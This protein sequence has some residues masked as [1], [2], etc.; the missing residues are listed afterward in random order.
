MNFS[1]LLITGW[2][3]GTQLLHPLQ[4]ALENHA[5]RVEVINIFDAFDAAV[6]QQNVALAR[7][8]DV[9]VGWSLGGQLAA[10]LVNEIE[11][12]YAEH[13][14][15]ITLA[16]NPC[17][18]A[19]DF[20][21]HA[22]PVATFKAFKQSFEH[23]AI[24]TLKRFGY[25]VCQGVLSTKTDLLTLQS[26]IQPQQIQLL[27]QGLVL[28]KNLNVV[29]ILKNYSGQ[30]Y[31]LFAMQD[32]LVPHQVNHD[33]QNLAAKYLNTDTILGAHAF[34]VT[35]PLM[36]SEQIYQYLRQIQSC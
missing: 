21:P 35:Q 4:Q 25:M 8:Y 20:W 11:K 16:S 12:K 17:F 29:D 24:N 33:L 23:D 31:H 9:I 5:H 30:Q 32:A 10:V 3:G 18:V 19:N 7:A 14:I 36:C 27:Q 28:L 6:L 2:G 26:L 1:I 22:M 13:K 15:L 34:P